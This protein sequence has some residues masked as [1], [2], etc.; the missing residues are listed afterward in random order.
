MEVWWIG[1]RRHCWELVTSC[2]ME[3][4]EE[5]NT[6]SLPDRFQLLQCVGSCQTCWRVNAC[7][8][9]KIQ[10]YSHPSRVTCTGATSS[11]M[12]AMSTLLSFHLLLAV[13]VNAGN[14]SLNTS[15]QVRS[16]CVTVSPP[17]YPLLTC[18]SLGTSRCLFPLVSTLTSAADIWSVQWSIQVSCWLG[19][20]WLS[21]SKDCIHK[22]RV[23]MNGKIQ[24]PVDQLPE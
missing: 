21:Y 24:K 15:Y 5:H 22:E 6:C 9:Q 12:P 10:T 11:T 1:N 2:M 4:R 13:T 20:N 8:R 18:I 23:P 14:Y 19:R 17:S 7:D 3:W 16:M